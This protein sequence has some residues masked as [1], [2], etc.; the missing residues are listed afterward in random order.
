[1][2]YVRNRISA[3]GGSRPDNASRD[4]ESSDGWTALDCMH[5][6]TPET[7]LATP[8]G[9]V[10]AQRLVPGDTLVSRAKGNLTV[11]GVVPVLLAR[12]SLIGQPRL[13]PICIGPGALGQDLPQRP[14]VVAPSAGLVGTPI[15]PDGSVVPVT[16]LVGRAQVARVF[17]ESM[18]YLRIV[19]SVPAEIM[20]EGVWLA[21]DQTGVDLAD[22]ASMSWPVS[23]WQRLAT[24]TA[25]LMAKE[26]RLFN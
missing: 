11:L 3:N 1:M 4:W 10:A 25:G 16:D 12:A 20:A 23:T 2:T 13:T 22:D 5:L 19:L 18:S 9:E 14:L 15:Q 17:P 7:R 6:V 26:K 24:V 21:P 8:K